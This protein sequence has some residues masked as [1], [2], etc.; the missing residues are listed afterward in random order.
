MNFV[1][2]PPATN[3]LRVCC[4]AAAIVAELETFEVNLHASC[5][6]THGSTQTQSVSLSDSCAR[7]KKGDV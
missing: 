4:T 6:K 1:M 5:S 2:D 7:R 3:A